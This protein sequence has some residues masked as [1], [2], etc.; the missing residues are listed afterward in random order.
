M[1]GLIYIHILRAK[2]PNKFQG[3]KLCLVI[4]QTSTDCSCKSTANIKVLQE[5]NLFQTC[6]RH[7]HAPTFSKFSLIGTINLFYSFIHVYPTNSVLSIDLLCLHE[8]LFRF[9]A[10]KYVSLL[11]NFHDIF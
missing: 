8:W 5:F 7:I 10:P 3:D 1:F 11:L 9:S 2:S 6:T 4:N